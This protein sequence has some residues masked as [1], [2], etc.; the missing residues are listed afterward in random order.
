M[1]SNS[2][3]TISNK[4]LQI[5]DSIYLKHMLSGSYF[6]ICYVK[7]GVVLKLSFKEHRN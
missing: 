5:F 3:L 4:Y 7:I 6:N 2:W 1:L